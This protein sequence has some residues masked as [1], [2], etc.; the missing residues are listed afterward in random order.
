MQRRSAEQRRWEAEQEERRLQ[1]EA[2]QRRWEA[3][4]RRWEA[5]QEERR[6]QRE[7]EQ[8]ERRL[9]REAEQ[10]HWEAEQEERR[11]QR[12]TEQRRWEA[13]PAAKQRR[14]EQRRAQREA[15]RSTERSEPDAVPTRT[16][17]GS[18]KPTL[19]RRRTTKLSER[20]PDPGRVLHSLQPRLDTLLSRQSLSR[21]QALAAAAVART[22]EERLSTGSHRSSI[23]T[24]SISASNGSSSGSDS[25][26]GQ[27]GD[28]FVTPPEPAPTTPSSPRTSSPSS[29]PVSAISVSLQDITTYPQGHAT[30]TLPGEYDDLNPVKPQAVPAREAHRSTSADSA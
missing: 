5:E 1:R 21:L 4:Q 19:L 28:V 17:L 26:D 9:Q 15:C 7:A 22:E 24:G 11:T 29:P 3:E 25:D 10:R 20:E 14:R 2:E 16:V 12:M 27:D 13:E 30:V 23:G 6:L 8:E 18:V